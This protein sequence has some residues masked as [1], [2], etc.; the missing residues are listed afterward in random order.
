M[1]EKFS[2]IDHR[3]IF[4]SLFIIIGL[5][6]VSN[7][8]REEIISVAAVY[9]IIVVAIGNIAYLYRWIRS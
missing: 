5:A 6:V 1:T 8:S 9:F 4:I 2:N 3:I 7:L